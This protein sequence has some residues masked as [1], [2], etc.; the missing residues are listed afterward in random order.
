[1]TPIVPF[2]VPPG[3]GDDATDDVVPGALLRQLELAGAR[4]VADPG[5]ARPARAARRPMAAQP[6]ARALAGWQGRTG[7]GAGR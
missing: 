7:H 3:A 1:M 5:D 6:A 4:K 2:S